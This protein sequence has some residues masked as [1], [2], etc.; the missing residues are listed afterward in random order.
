M[1]ERPKYF[2]SSEAANILGV[3]VSTIK[4]WT[5]DGRL[6]CIKT[7]GGHRK[8]AISHLAEFIQEN[9]QKTSRVNVFPVE[10]EKDLEISYHIT[11]GDFKFLKNRVLGDALDCN[12]ERIHKILNGLY[13]GQFP[14]HK[15]YDNLITPVMHR[16]GDLW[17]R[18]EITITEE[19]FASQIIRD[20]IIRLQ[21]AMQ[22]PSKKIGT[23]LC[24]NFSSEL[25]D[26]ALKLVDHI[27][28]IRG[29]KVLFSGQ[30]TPLYKLESIFEKFQ[31]DRVYI[32]STVVSEISLA[33]LE[34][35]HLL[36]LCEN[37]SAEVY[38]GGRGMDK[39]NIDHPA[40]TARLKS[41]KEVYKT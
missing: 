31:P 12:R 37:N 40:I 38:V 28:E 35:N 2:N 16:I 22:I 7:A 33:Q 27:L 3:N 5:D 9:K 30:I 15:I 29:Y 10:G 26:I 13:L 39:L 11:K 32:S 21:S 4:R 8:F 18:E 1:P 24:L 17:E 34:L 19:H 23:A 6:K 25:H 20:S 14:L 36:E 41:F